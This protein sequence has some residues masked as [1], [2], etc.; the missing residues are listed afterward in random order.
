LVEQSVEVGARAG[1]AQ[2]LEKIV[3]GVGF[4]EAPHEVVE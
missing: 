2:T 3:H 4:F 1:V